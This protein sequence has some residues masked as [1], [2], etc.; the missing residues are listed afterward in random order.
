[1][2]EVKNID[3]KVSDRYLIKS[4]SFT[5]Q[6]GDKM[7]IIG[8]E[9]NG[10]STLLKA[11]LGICNYA[12]IKGTL[13]DKNHT[14]GYLEQSMKEETLKKKVYDFLFEDTNNYYNKVAMFYTYLENLEL[15]DTILERELSFLSGGERVKIGIVKLL[16][17][18]VDILFLDEPTN[19]LD[20]KTLEWLENFIKKTDK[21]VLYVSHD[22]TLLSKTANKILHLELVKKKKVCK[23][24]LV[25]MSYDAY[26]E[27]RLQAIDHQ[28]QVA[29]FEKRQYLKK[30]DRLY[31]IMQKVKYQQATITRKDPH[32]AKLL[33]K[34]MHSLKSQEKKLENTQ[35]TE[36]PDVEES[37]SF[38][39]E[40]VKIP[41]SKE[42]V[43]MDIP[44]LSIGT[45]ELSKNIQLK[46]V[47][48]PHICIVGKN[49]AGKTTLLKQIYE[50]LKGR[51]DLKVGFMPQVYEEVLKS[52]DTVLDFFNFS[53]KED[54]TKARMYLGNMNFTK[55]E[56]EGKIENLS[57]GTKAK[58]FLIKF[59]LEK[60]DVLLLDEPTRNVSPL[61]NPVIRNVL[62]HFKGTI[63]SVSHDRKYI[64][65]VIDC[66]YLLKE[67]GIKEIKK[68]EMSF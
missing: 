56:M 32:G 46:I 31:Q 36:V 63:I 20:I 41:K 18:E 48:T 44:K 10:K 42:I 12:E 9:G 68:E 51:S 21:P 45:K 27:S 35:L 25:K 5:L 57:N 8:E 37:I 34:K 3:I 30:Q 28:T 54:L 7:A 50:N 24:T 16:L 47:G 52:Y 40:E 61:S 33:K 38:C 17:E 49:G 1:M 59:V 6:K 58:L 62:K 29:R 43:I 23:H 19:D 26:I 14:I 39:F 65:E 22:E 4:L 13:Q 66:G 53:K 2:F 55:E 67:D 64:E 60:C 11:L 15:E